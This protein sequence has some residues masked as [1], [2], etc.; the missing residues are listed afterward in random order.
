[1]GLNDGSR[2]TGYF[3]TFKSHRS[4]NEDGRRWFRSRNSRVPWIAA[5]PVGRT[6]KWGRASLLKESSRVKSFPAGPLAFSVT[7]KHLGKEAPIP[8]YPGEEG[9]GYSSEAHWGHVNWEIERLLPV[10]EAGVICR[11]N[12]LRYIV[13]D[14]EPLQIPFLQRW[15]FACLR[16]C[17]D[18][19]VWA[20]VCMH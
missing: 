11:F 20:C 12:W 19:R 18:V 15:P 2:G 8:I 1:M 13:E 6:P 17:A 10:L 5:I 9:A 14:K 7:D 3:G 4:H 16:V